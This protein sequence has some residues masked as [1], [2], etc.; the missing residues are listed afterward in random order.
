MTSTTSS[1]GTCSRTRQRIR[2]NTLTQRLG[3][4]A[5][6][7]GR[8]LFRENDKRFAARWLGSAASSVVCSHGRRSV[9]PACFR[10]RQSRQ[11]SCA[12]LQRESATSLSSRP[13]RNKSGVGTPESTREP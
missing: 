9:C 8:S 1:C 5:C 11:G 4:Y 3:R 2:Q 12:S 6:R 10:A 13:D 7:E